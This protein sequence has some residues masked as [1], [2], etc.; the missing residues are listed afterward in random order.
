MKVPHGYSAQFVLV[1]SGR[2]SVPFTTE[3]VSQPNS[4]EE[5]VRYF[6]VTLQVYN[7]F[8]IFTL[9]VLDTS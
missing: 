3:G 5:D 1:S 7:C 4:M 9:A 6:L 2:I 8:T